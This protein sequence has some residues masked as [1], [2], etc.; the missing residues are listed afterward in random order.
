MFSG[1]F[2]HSTS[3]K[4][5]MFGS[6]EDDLSMRPSTDFPVVNGRRQIVLHVRSMMVA[7]GIRSSAALQRLLISA[8][9]QISQAQL[10]R[11]IDN[12]S[13]KVNM[14]VLN[15]LLNVFRCS[16]HDLVG[17]EAVRDASVSQVGGE[18]EAV[19]EPGP[20]HS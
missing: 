14:D 13:L 9:V 6:C 15:G 12:K 10:L 4:G 1:I 3:Q 8:G 7:R 5:T 2:V 17:E 19:D 20:T 11:I 18:M 16:V